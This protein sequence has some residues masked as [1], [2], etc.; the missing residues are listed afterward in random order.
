MPNR[1]QSTGQPNLARSCSAEAS[2]RRNKVMMAF[3]GAG[4]PPWMS[5]KPHASSRRDPSK[6]R[7]FLAWPPSAHS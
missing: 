3:G 1:L 6:A 4:S 5:Q 2:K 7:R